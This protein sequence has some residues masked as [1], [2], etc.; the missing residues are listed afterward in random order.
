MRILLVNNFHYLRGGAEKSNFDTAE[1]LKDNEH[2]I[3][4]FST[5]NQNNFPTEWERYFVNYFDL[6]VGHGFKDKLRIIGRIFYNPEA[7]RNIRKLI[8]DFRPDVAHLHNVYHHLSPSVIGEFKRQGIPVVMTLHD[9]KLVCPNYN[10]FARGKIWERSKKNKYY[11]CFW[12][13][14]V[15]DSYAK[16]AICTLEAYAHKIMGVYRNVDI[17]ISPS[18]FLINKFREF[19]FK[20]N[21]RYLPNP[22]LEGADKETTLSE[23]KDRYVLYFGRLSQEKGVDDLIS[24]YKGLDIRDIKLKIVGDGP[25]RQELR[26]LIDTQG[27]NG[28]IEL[29]GPK[30]GQE[31]NDIIAGAELI[32]FPFKWY[33]NY[34]YTV[35]EAQR[36]GKLIICSNMG[37]VGE[38]IKDNYSGFLYEAGNIKQL[39]ELMRSVIGEYESL[40]HVGDNAKREVEKN[41]NKE[42]FYKELITIYNSIV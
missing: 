6:E 17:F 7:R 39:S 41:N 35:L 26:E 28:R 1:I 20:V 8:K 5:R 19:G 21:I 13:K 10:L 12:D 27:L 33:E 22:L 32:V 34:P 11:R 37:G 36:A 14:C 29:P 4:F 31:L 2:E 38:M 25:Q 9:Y 42:V 15:K 18:R 23:K 3:A 16:S 40:K 30:Y 24:A